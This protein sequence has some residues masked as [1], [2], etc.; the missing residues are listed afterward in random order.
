MDDDI[1]GPVA[2]DDDKASLL[3]LDSIANER[4]DARIPLK[5]SV[6]HI[7]LDTGEA[8]DIHCFANHIF[9]VISV[10]FAC[11][12]QYEPGLKRLETESSKG[13]EMIKLDE[14]CD[15]VVPRELFCRDTIRP[16]YIR[17]S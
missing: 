8:W 4:G 1:L 17:P 16:C 7:F 10:L 14:P 9:D 11:G 3:F 13:C 6:E 12:G 15:K 5:V 2:N